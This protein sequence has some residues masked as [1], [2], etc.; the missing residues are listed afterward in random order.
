M[1]SIQ[2]VTSLKSV[3]KP[4]L[5]KMYLDLQAKNVAHDIDESQELIHL[6]GQVAKYRD[7]DFTKEFE[8]K[9]NVEFTET[10]CE[11]YNVFCEQHKLSDDENECFCELMYSG[12]PYKTCEK[13]MLVVR[14]SNC[15]LIHLRSEVAK[16]HEAQSYLLAGGPNAEAFETRLIEMKK[17]N[18]H[19]KEENEQLKSKLECEDDGYPVS[20]WFRSKLDFHI[21]YHFTNEGGEYYKPL[22]YLSETPDNLDELIYG[23]LEKLKKENEKLKGELD[24]S[25]ITE[26][27]SARN[28][29]MT[30]LNKVKKENEKLEDRIGDLENEIDHE[31][32]TQ[33]QVEQEV[34]E[35]VAELKKEIEELKKNTVPKE[36]LFTERIAHKELKESHNN[37]K[38]KL[39]NFI[40]A[41]NQM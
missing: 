3:K 40:H 19:L 29:L 39:E 15:E 23:T 5:V 6:R 31:L 9:N 14:R 35:K 10:E 8:F 24:H 38:R 21:K 1:T 11:K 4:D 12:M 16:Y 25:T 28:M 32:Y 7:A 30:E 41:F 33:E 27:R 22:K 18:E 2:N 37:T 20:E 17:E 13:T 34:E 26:V 36:I